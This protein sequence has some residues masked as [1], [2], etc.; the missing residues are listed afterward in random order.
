MATTEASSVGVQPKLKTVV[1]LG[2]VREGRYG[3]RVAKFI[4]KQLEEANHSV[5]LFGK[6]INLNACLFFTGLVFVQ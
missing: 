5:D 1:F 6:Y 2:S 3:L 4:I